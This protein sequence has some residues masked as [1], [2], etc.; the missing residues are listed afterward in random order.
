[1]ETPG[2]YNTFS[3]FPT[4]LYI[5]STKPTAM[6]LTSLLIFVLCPAVLLAQA[7][8]TIDE[9]TKGLKKHE[10]Y[11]D[12]YWDDVAGKIWLEIDKMDTEILYNISMPAAIGSNDIGL[13]RGLLG[14]GRI[15]IFNRV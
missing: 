7:L 6:R 4:L 3:R 9:K 1:M 12:F 10:G 5:V 13:D 14:D 8:P 11:F 15:V 2:I